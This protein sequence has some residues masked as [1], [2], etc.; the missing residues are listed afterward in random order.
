MR[1]IIGRRKTGAK[2]VHVV[3]STPNKPMDPSKPACAGRHGYAVLP[4]YTVTGAGLAGHRSAVG[5][6]Q[7]PSPNSPVG[8]VEVD[9]EMLAPLCTGFPSSWES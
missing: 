3:D 2:L 1:S 8:S 5:R 7:R 4:T 9:T 6:M